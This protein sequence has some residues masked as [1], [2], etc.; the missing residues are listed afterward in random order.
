M[1]RAIIDLRSV[2]WPGLLVGKDVEFGRKVMFEEKEVL[3]NSASYGY[4][5]A[6]DHLLIVLDELKI[7][8]RDCILVDE[9]RN[10]KLMR[11]MMFAGY[12]A[13]RDQAPE[14]KDQF[15]IAKADLIKVFL[16]MGAQVCWQDGME[17]DDVIGYLAQNLKGERYVVTNDGDLCVLIDPD[18][19]INVYKG[20]MLNYNP[21]GP[22]SPKYITVYKA[23][24]GDS[25][26]KYPGAYKFGE[27]AFLKML[28]LFNEDGLEAMDLL[29]RG[30]QLNRLSEDVDA[31]KELQRVIDHAE[32]VYTCYALAKLYTEKV[33]T[34]RKPL[35]WRVGMVKDISGCEDHRLR[36]FY[37]Q[38]RLITAENYD[39]AVAWAKKHIEASPYASLDIETSTPPES[40]EWLMLQNKDDGNVVDVFGSRLTGLGTT[41]GD[42]CQYT[43]YL[44]YDHREEPGV[45]NLTLQQVRDFVDLI[46]RRTKTIVHNA[47]FELPVLY[48]EWGEDW[49]DDPEWHGFLRNVRD[50]RIA[51]SYVD[52]NLKAG[53]KNLSSHYLGY[54]QVTY[55]QVTTKTFPAEDYKY[56]MGGKVVRAYDDQLHGDALVD[57]QFKMNELTANRVLSYGADDCICTAALYNHFLTRMELENV[58]QVFDEVETL[59]AYLTAKAFVDGADF[60][61]ETMIRMSNDDDK[62]YDAAWVI[63]R[64]YLIDRG[65]EGTQTPVF[66]EINPANVKEAFMI[67]TGQK[68]DTMVRM[69]DKLS[70]FILNWAEDGEASGEDEEM[71]D[72]VRL[73]GVA[74]GAGDLDTLNKVVAECFDGEPK[75]DLASPKQMK[76]LLYDGMGIPIKIVND[77]TDLEKQHDKVLSETMRR[78]KKFRAG[79]TT[80][81]ITAE[82]YAVLKKK[83]KT[84]DTAIAFALA[85]DRDKLSDADA[86]ALDAIGK[87]K[88]V[89]TRRSLFYKNYR[90]ILHWKDGK[91]HASINQCGTVTRRYSSSKPNLQ[92]LPKKGEGVK[93]RECFRPHH[94]DAVVCSIDFSGQELRLA[95][96][97]SQDKNMLSCYIGENLRDIHSITAS[98]AMKLKWGAEVVQELYGRFGSDDDYSVFIKARAL[99]KADTLGKKADD[100]RKDSKNVNFAAQFGGKAPKI[101]ETIVMPLEDAQL[102]LDA[103]NEMFPDV[104]V[105][106]ERAADKC[107]ATGYASTFL[108]ARRHLREGITSDNK[109]AVERAAR[110]AWNMEIQG[111]AAEMTKL[112]MARLWKSDFL[113][114]FDARFIAPVHD[115]LITSISTRDALDAI[116]IKHECMTKKY[117]DMEVPVWGSISLGPNLGQ[118]IECGDWLIP[119]NI[120][121]A[122]ASVSHE[123]KK[124]A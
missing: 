30:K 54:E 77:L 73:L 65:W 34:L 8:P 89:M 70:K 39:D 28:E 10:S 62:T 1:K 6:I 90:N 40:D 52:E 121:S 106:A 85:F 48:G 2:L 95:A 49:K 94:R 97:K 53:L 26:D 19:G 72:K 78:F 24:V 100:L 66:T 114:K 38:V 45:T 4:D 59:P 99:G 16:E 27:K 104:D 74:V 98:G 22:F 55:E 81:E 46:P 83:A 93:F 116:K 51:S 102:F 29:I 120:S 79:D 110:Q 50:T 42:N 13:G 87:M 31:M 35:E 14:I 56:E 67:V 84:D 18:N 96:W 11:E 61:L 64:Q 91:I 101:S 109:G 37:G 122:I 15:N 117:A 41:F 105:A 63:L 75:L 57:V 88:T 103:R 71:L 69:A 12:K 119:E 60:D 32:D 82:D 80:V 3:V 107:K 20:G 44:T 36:K 118:Q 5:N 108:G 123:H 86:E 25:S 23:L 113:W 7:K 58:D 112:A 124:A 21:F 92:Q 68:L 17:A 33:N 47:Q 43:F 111:S 115:E 76:A 9:G